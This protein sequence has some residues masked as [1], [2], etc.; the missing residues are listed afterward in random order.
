MEQRQSLPP[1]TRP[2]PSSPKRRLEQASPGGRVCVRRRQRRR[3]RNDGRDKE[4]QVR[5]P[6]VTWGTGEG[7]DIRWPSQRQ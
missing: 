6:E 5:A 4:L 7:L 3:E 2:P 1:S